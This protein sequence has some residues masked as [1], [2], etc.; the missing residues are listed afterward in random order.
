MR[1]GTPSPPGPRP[2][3]PLPGIIPP[4]REFRCPVCG[5]EFLSRQQLDEHDRAEHRMP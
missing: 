4:R 1:A 2:E 3:Q 5:A